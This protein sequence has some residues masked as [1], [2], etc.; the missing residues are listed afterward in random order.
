MVYELGE[1]GDKERS[2][3]IPR[4]LISGRVQVESA[5][6]FFSCW[7]AEKARKLIGTFR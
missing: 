6:T 5:V 4:S 1:L 7:T 3:G 2:G